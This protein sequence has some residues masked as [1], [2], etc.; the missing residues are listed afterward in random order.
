MAKLDMQGKS[1]TIFCLLQL[2]LLLLFCCNAVFVHQLYALR[3]ISEYAVLVHRMH[4]KSQKRHEVDDF[5]YKCRAFS[6]NIIYLNVY[7][8][9]AAAKASCLECAWLMQAESAV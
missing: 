3:R 9:H 8:L 6:K 1:P 7:G 5:L 2:Q 4:I